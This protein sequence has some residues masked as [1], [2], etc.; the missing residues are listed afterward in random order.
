MRQKY[1]Y[2][3]PRVTYETRLKAH[4]STLIFNHS[5][6]LVLDWH[7]HKY[8]RMYFT[9]LLSGLEVDALHVGVYL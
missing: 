2:N 1:T 6:L 8:I 3:I 7:Y 5:A 4:R 9:T